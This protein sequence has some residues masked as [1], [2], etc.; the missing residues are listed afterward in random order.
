[1]AHTEII[2]FASAGH[3]LVGTLTVADAGRPG[4]S[5]VLISGSGPI[6]RDSNMKRMPIDVMAQVAE[7]LAVTGVSS[8]R[9]D[10]RG[11][12]D[13]GGEYQA[14]GFHDNVDDGL[15]ALAALRARAEVAADRTFVVGHSEG[16]LIAG[17]MAVTDPSIAGVVLL[18]GAAR[19][20]EDILVWQMA[21]IGDSLPGPVKILTK[22]LRLDLAKTQRK[23]LDEIKASTQDVMRLQMVKVN[24]KWFRE[25]M[26][27]DPTTAVDGMTVPMLAI[28]GDKD[29]QVDPDDLERMANLVD[30]DFTSHRPRD[31]THLLRIDA[32]PASVRTYRKQVRRPVDPVTLDLV[33]EWVVDRAAPEEPKHS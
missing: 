33:A 15:A 1:M 24:A 9:Y 8:L 21:Q 4:P 13:S 17:E 7:R 12:G 20:G 27:Y 11:V 14:T 29:V 19:N 26:A 3:T 28:T 10:K 22:V 6:D 16:A 31:L 32:G 5:A 2:S 30:G 18:A 25:F 23:R